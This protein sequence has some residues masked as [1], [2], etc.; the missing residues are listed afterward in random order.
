MKSELDSLISNMVENRQADCYE[1][2]MVVELRQNLTLLLDK[3]T[4]EKKLNLHGKQKLKIHVWTLQ[5]FCKRMEDMQNAWD[6][7]NK[8]LSILHENK[9]HYIQTINFRLEY[10]FTCAAEGEIIGQHLL[11]VTHQKAIVAENAE[12]IRA[13]EGLV[14]TT[15]S[16]K[17]R[18]KYLKHLADGVRR[19]ENEA[20]LAY[21]RS[22]TNEIEVWYRGV[23]DDH[24][25]ESFGRT[26]AKTF[27]QE[28]KSV[29][30]KI[31]KASDNDEIV[32]IAQSANVESLYYQPSCDINGYDVNVMK[33]KI[34]STNK[35]NK[36]NFCK[37]DERLLSRPSDDSGVMSRL[38]CTKTCYFCGAMCWGQKG[39]EKDQGETRKHHSSH[40]PVGLSGNV[41]STSNHLFPRPCH[42]ISNENTVYFGDYYEKGILWAEAKEKHFGDWTFDRH[43]ISKFDKLMRWFFQELHRDIAKNTEER[44]PATPEDL[45]R[46][47]CINLKYDDIISRIN[48]EIN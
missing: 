28:F 20:A 40:Q 15:N 24:R 3:I 11:K 17:V 16:E 25:S 36:E 30:C 22:P 44:K 37:L 39:H 10:G 31:E 42:D 21:F 33:N 48:Q 32:S 7:K 35:E 2:G 23:V 8:P 34:L 26:F 47:N 4:S 41:Y 27:E 13:V 12:K 45:K 5:Q 18:L 43:C 9:E 14:W 29:L 1:H 46:Y 38:G 19:G 6:E